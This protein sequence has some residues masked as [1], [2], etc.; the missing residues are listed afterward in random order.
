MQHPGSEFPWPEF[1]EERVPTFAQPWEARAFALVLAASEKGSFSLKDFQQALIARVGTHEKMSCIASNEDY[2][3]RWIEALED[4][5]ISHGVVSKDR[6]GAS[7]SHVISTAA[8]RKEHQ[9][10][11]ARDAEGNLRIAPL[12]IDPA[13]A[14][15]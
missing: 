11:T 9:H 1:V 5:L 4:I 6:I 8:L 3:S 12:V 15:R 13:P 2:Y 14:S 10:G 7:E